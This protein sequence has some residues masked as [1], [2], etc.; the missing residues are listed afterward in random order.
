MTSHPKEPNRNEELRNQSQTELDNYNIFII[1]FYK[2]WHA[3]HKTYAVI[4]FT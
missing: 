2:I 1:H 3:T 4:F